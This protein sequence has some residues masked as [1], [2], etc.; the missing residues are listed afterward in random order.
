MKVGTV[1]IIIGVLQVVFGLTVFGVVAGLY[2]SDFSDVTA[3]ISNFDPEEIVAAIVCWIYVIAGVFAILCSCTKFNSIRL[4]YMIL[5]SMS[6]YT[7]GL[8][9]FL[10]AIE[11]RNCLNSILCDDKQ[12]QLSMA[13][14]ALNTCCALFA[15]IGLGAVFRALK[16]RLISSD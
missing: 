11:L 10:G 16:K 9:V 15:L 8:F 3:S 1:L 4:V 6:T 12:K 5:A 13:S 14:V 2:K 7:S